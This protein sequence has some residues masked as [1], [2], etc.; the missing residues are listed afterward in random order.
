MGVDVVA[1]DGLRLW[2]RAR[3]DGE[4]IRKGP[5]LHGIQRIEIAILSGS[6][7]TMLE[8]DRAVGLGSAARYRGRR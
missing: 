7:I 5:A 3:G 2:G 6:D 1:M 4:R 8:L